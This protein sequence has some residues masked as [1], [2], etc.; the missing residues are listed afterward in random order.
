M[1]LFCLKTFIGAGGKRLNWKIECDALNKRDFE[2]IAS[3][4]S[5][6]LGPFSSVTGIP[7]GGL[8]LAK[9]FEQYTTSSVSKT[10]R[11][12]IVDDVWTT[13]KTM[14]TYTS[15]MKDWIGFVIFAR[16]PTPENVLYLFKT[17]F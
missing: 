13:G 15:N 7:S 9:A 6:I 10:G 8:L 3:V 17:D 14:T 16:S 12:L 4:I 1:N 11:P 2:C 5:P